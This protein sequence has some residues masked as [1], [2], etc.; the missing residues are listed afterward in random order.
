METAKAVSDEIVRARLYG[1]G[2][3]RRRF[4]LTLKIGA[5]DETSLNQLF[6]VFAEQIVRGYIAS[7][8]GGGP[9]EGTF[10]V[11][12]NSDQTPEKWKEEM[13]AWLAENKPEGV[14]S[15]KVGGL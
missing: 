9:C 3:P 5:D 10:E 8:A 11:V 4:E 7:N 12:V 14:P 15:R 2:A 13:E 6:R 1:K